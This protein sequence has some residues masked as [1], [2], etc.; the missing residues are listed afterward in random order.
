MK[1]A[2][3]KAFLLQPI[4]FVFHSH[5]ISQPAIDGGMSSPNA[6]FYDIRDSAISFYSNNPDT[7]ESGSE[8]HFRSWEW[9][10]Q[11]R[12]DKSGQAR[13]SFEYVKNALKVIVA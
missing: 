2:I 6:D 10:W 11:T 8:A 4:L 7:S 1:S 12:V 5:L 3:L 9:F 13:G